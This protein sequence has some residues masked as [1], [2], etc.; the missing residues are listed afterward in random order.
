M[1]G[2]HDKNRQNPYIH[3]AYILIGETDKNRIG[4]TLNVVTALDSDECY[5]EKS[6]KWGTGNSEQVTRDDLIERV[7]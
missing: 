6:R 2:I 5:G 4:K 1:L 7:A 3:E